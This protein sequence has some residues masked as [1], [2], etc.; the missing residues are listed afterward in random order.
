MPKSLSSE[1]RLNLVPKEK[2]T[3]LPVAAILF[4]AEKLKTHEMP[5]SRSLT[6]HPF[7]VILQLLRLM[8][9]HRMVKMKK[10]E[11]TKCLHRFGVPLHCWWEGKSG[12]KPLWKMVWQ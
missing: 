1:K 5:I 7:Y 2:Q 6:V 12:K 3:R 11:N 9:E 10:M 4:M 8:I